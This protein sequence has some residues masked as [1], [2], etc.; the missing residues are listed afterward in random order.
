MGA[1]LQF[2]KLRLRPGQSVIADP[3]SLMYK[4]S[5]IQIDTTLG[6]GTEGPGIMNKLVSAGKRLLIGENLFLNR[7]HNRTQRT[8]EIAFSSPFPRMVNGRCLVFCRRLFPSTYSVT[9]KECPW[10]S[11]ISFCA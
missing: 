9:M 4:Q 7:W 10:A 6:D 8:C 3:G 5:G 1:E 11:S 2:V